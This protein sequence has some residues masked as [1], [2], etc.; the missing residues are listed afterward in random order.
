LS[1]TKAR[2]KVFGAKNK[3]EIAG[4]TVAA[5]TGT[6]ENYSD[7]WTVGYTPKITV[8]VWM[9]NNNR[10]NTKNIS[11]IDGAGYIWHDLMTSYL[12]TEADIPFEKPEGLSEVWINPYTFSLAPKTGSPYTLEYYLPGTEPSDKPDFSYL[13][14]FSRSYSRY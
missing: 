7:S 8:G 10:I 6:T 1:D 3:L 9:G 14:S 2:Q 12:T 5:K 11:G 4:H 13:S